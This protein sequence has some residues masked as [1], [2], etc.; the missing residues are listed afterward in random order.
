MAGGRIV[1]THMCGFK[2]SSHISE[3]YGDRGLVK[4]PMGFMTSSKCVAAQLDRRCNGKHDHVHL[5]GLG[6]SSAQVYPQPLCEAMLRGIAQQKAR[7]ACNQLI[8][9]KMNNNQL[10]KFV[11]S[12][13][14]VD[15]CFA[16]SSSSTIAPIGDWCKHW[17]HPVHEEDG[18]NDDFGPRPP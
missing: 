8:T 3:T 5:V 4:K 17:I 7:D 10:K 14:S 15:T 2:M 16:S 11:G 6:A 13:A 9:P 18:G 12:L 1:E